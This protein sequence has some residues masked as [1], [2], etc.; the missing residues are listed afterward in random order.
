METKGNET[1]VAAI[2]SAILIALLLSGCATAQYT[3]P[4][5]MSQKN[6]FTQTL[7]ETFDD[8]WKRLVSY[9]SKSFYSIENFEKDSGLMTLSFS[10]S[11]FD[12]YVDCG[13]WSIKA[14]QGFDGP[15]ARY[16][17]NKGAT[18]SGKMNII[19]VS[20]EK[21]KSILTV[22]ARYIITSTT[23]GRNPFSGQYFSFTDTWTFDTNGKG[24]ITVRNPAPGPGTPVRTCMP[25]HKL[26]TEIIEGIAE[27]IPIS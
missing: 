11:S 6:R 10:L 17:Q 25:T 26:E 15:Y 24:S 4:T 22:R 9:A 13:M 14:M 16:I 12:E 18:L 20:E 5:S 21:N 8:A 7:D 3:P 23:Q 19:V 27:G 2:S 1:N